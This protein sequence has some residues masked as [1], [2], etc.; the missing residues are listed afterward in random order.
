MQISH[1]TVAIPSISMQIDAVQ[2]FR[3]NMIAADRADAISVQ[4]QPL[5]IVHSQKGFVLDA[6]DL[7]IAQFERGQ[8]R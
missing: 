2:R 4:T 6:F 5:Q 8:K 7:T 3:Q 1:M